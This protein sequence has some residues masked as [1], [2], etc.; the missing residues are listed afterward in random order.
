ME[1]SVEA[2]M[3][4]LGSRARLLRDAFTRFGVE[5]MFIGKASALG[6]GYR[7]TTQDLDIYPSKQTENRTRLVDALLSVGFELNVEF[8]G[9]TVD[10]KQQILDARDFVRLFEPFELDIVF[11]PDGF[12]SYENTARQYRI[13]LEGFPF[14][15][16]EG[17][18]TNKRSAK[19]EK[20]LVDLPL[21]ENFLKAMKS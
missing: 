9:R 8:G 17:I 19:R 14:L 11:A 10:L 16:I 6:Q 18:I 4:Y 3:G 15:S 1:G 5:Y 7:G 12:E 21:L 2:R 13:V 20:D